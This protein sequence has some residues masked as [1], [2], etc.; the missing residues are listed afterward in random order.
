MATTHSHNRKS[1]AVKRILSEA[2][3]LA[4]DPS[5]EYKAQPLEDNIFEW[6][7]TLRGP[8]DTE[9]Q[10]GL[11]HGRILLPPEYPFRPPNL[12]LL[13]PNGRWELNKKICLSFTGYHEEM[14]QPAWGIRTALLGMQSLMAAR[15]K[16]AIGIGALDYPEHERIRLA[17][18]S[19]DWACPTCGDTCAGI[20]GSATRPESSESQ[21]S[22]LPEGLSVD[23]DAET[24]KAEQVAAKSQETD[25]SPILSSSSIA[26]TRTTAL[27]TPSNST[28][29]SISEEERASPDHSGTSTPQM[30][31]SE[32]TPHQVIRTTHRASAERSDA[33][34]A[35]SL[36][37]VRE[38][39]PVALTRLSTSSSS[40]PRNDVSTNGPEGRRQA[41]PASP[42]A[43]A[44]AAAVPAANANAVV[45]AAA[46]PPAASGQLALVD[47]C[48]AA[49]TLLIGVLLLRMLIL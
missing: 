18:K 12:M 40:G 39:P 32:I 27:L 48:I 17:M 37:A 43:A 26:A 22:A 3:E 11:Y 19:K 1:S 44:A 24:R 31:H 46:T 6:H 13:T 5:H 23:A 47:R 21:P 45:A 36:H 30:I 14:W 7:F 2:N 16:A 41:L 34:T 20:L 38:V 9:F 8:T 10:H 49:L 25:S 4:R 15:A 33:T 42:P 35:P 29:L 28:T